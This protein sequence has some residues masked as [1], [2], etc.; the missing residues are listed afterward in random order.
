MSDLDGPVY[1]DARGRT[2][3]TW[4]G[5]RGGVSICGNH[6]DTDSIGFHNIKAPMPDADKRPT[7]EQSWPPLLAAADAQAVG[8]W[9]LVPRGSAKQWAYR[10]YPVYRSVLDEH[11]GEVNGIGVGRWTRIAAN[12]RARAARTPIIA[13]VG[14]PPGVTV[15]PSR[16]GPMLA[17]DN[18]A[19]PLYVPDGSATVKRT[20][21]CSA[22]CRTTWA[23][24]EASAL[25]R[26]SGDW[27]ILAEGLG[28][29]QWAFKGKPLFARR[30]A[31]ADQQLPLED[32]AGWRPAILRTLPK[33]PMKVGIETTSIGD[34]YATREG[35]TLYIFDC[36]EET[37]ERLYCD[38]LGTT[39][40]YRLGICGAEKCSQTFFPLLAD[41]GDRALN[42]TWS[43][44]KVD[45][46]TG[47][48]LSNDSK[49]ADAWAYRGRPVY[50]YV[51]D[52]VA[53]D[54]N[55]DD[56]TIFGIGGY[57]VLMVKRDD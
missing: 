17:I 34:V 52:K 4:A 6:R 22:E 36:L 5:D 53:G 12:D 50:T 46:A 56:M 27:S 7:C 8:E 11:P 9:A 40:A 16:W 19:T 21:S 1:A 45:P 48:R 18:G 23:P 43:I 41:K 24:L 25:A 55:A 20:A 26:P 13:E 42:R 49:G 33:P 29:R 28:D 31:L 32:V 47:A 44:I 2:L 38:V 39:Q 3:Y 54:L 15:V 35:K 51:K 30:L 14:L 10:G 57:E 37:A